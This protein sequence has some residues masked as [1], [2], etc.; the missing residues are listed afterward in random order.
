MYTLSTLAD[1]VL[2]VLGVDTRTLFTYWVAWLIVLKITL[3]GALILWVAFKKIK[4]TWLR[5]NSKYLRKQFTNLIEGFLREDSEISR[6]ALSLEIRYTLSRKMYRLFFRRIVLDA[7]KLESGE[8]FSRLIEL[9]RNLEFTKI[10]FKELQDVRWWVKLSAL[11][12]LELLEDRN[13]RPFFYE[14]MKD[15]NEMIALVGMRA[16]GK[17]EGP[18]EI[19]SILDHL[20]RRAPARADLFAEL[21]RDIGEI[22]PS[23]VLKYLVTCSDPWIAVI[24]IQV[25]GELKATTAIEPLTRLSRSHVDE[26]AEVCIEALGKMGEHRVIPTIEAALHHSSPGVRVAAIRGLS[27]MKVTAPLY[28]FEL[29]GRDPDIKVQREIFLATR[30][31]RS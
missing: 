20:S 3:L 30:K 22:H 7:L 19:E 14:A 26:V 24:C 8:R 21:I 2:D 1:R 18:H 5:R 16:L 10:D 27:Q 15:P 25:L 13:L 6:R 11:L 28:R 9:Y 12:R 17:V 23:L 29:L 4:R 31:G